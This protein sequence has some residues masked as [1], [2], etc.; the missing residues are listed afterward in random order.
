MGR[1]TKQADN[2]RVPMMELR[3]CVEQMRDQPCTANSSGSRDICRR[4][5]MADGP[6][7]AP[8]DSF[9]HSG[10]YTSDFR[11]SSDDTDADAVRVGF[12]CHEP[13]F[14]DGKVFGAVDFF[15]GGVAVC[16]GEEELWSVSTALGHLD[17]WAFGMPAE[18]GGGGGG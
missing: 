8:L 10:T 5:T 17:E 16:G 9:L 2:R 13:I 15:E 14:L 6:Y 1:S 11:G 7:D 3:H 12:A 18:H 4:H